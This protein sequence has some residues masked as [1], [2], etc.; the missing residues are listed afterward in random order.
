MF[1]DPAKGD[2]RVNEGSP[3]LKIGFKNFPMD[4]FGVLKP[5]LKAIA[6][7]PLLPTV[8]IATSS[9]IENPKV[10]ATWLGASVA[11][12]SGEEFSAFGVRKEDGGIQ[13]LKVLPESQPAK[14]GL[15]A[16][17][18]VQSINSQPVKTLED[19]RKA[20]ETGKGKPLKVGFVRSQKEQAA[21]IQ[22]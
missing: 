15:R 14:A 4:Q 9:P 21:V 22:P 2:Y 1:I 10:E 5:E 6:R 7:T 17:D 13:I 3:A 11:A 12:L 20:S 19:L 16:G 18:L 8:K